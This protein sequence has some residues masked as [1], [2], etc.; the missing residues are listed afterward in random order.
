MYRFEW[1]SH[2][3][4]LNQVK[5]GIAFLDAVE[6]WQDPDL[7]RIPSKVA[8][9]DEDRCLYIGRIKMKIW[10]AITTERNDAIRIISVRR[11][12]KN[13]EKLYEEKS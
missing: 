2:N 3:S 9:L 7:L 4:E 11:A 10:V 5:H 8:D 12:R 6:L 1:D 13:E